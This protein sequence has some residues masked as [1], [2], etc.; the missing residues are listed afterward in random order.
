AE[1]VKVPEGRQARLLD[2]TVRIVAASHEPARE[3]V[4]RIEMRKDDVV[5]IET[6]GGS[7]VF[8]V[9]AVECARHGQQPQWLASPSSAESTSPRNWLTRRGL[10]EPLP[11]QVCASRARCYTR[12]SSTALHHAAGSYQP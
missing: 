12:A 6:L 2:Y 11:R 1:G 10:R 7:D 3:V 4:R 5:E 9:H 8:T